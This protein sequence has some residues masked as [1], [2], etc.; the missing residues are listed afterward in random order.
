MSLADVK[1]LCVDAFSASKTRTPIFNGLT[2]F[3]SE[4]IAN[5][6]AG[7]LWI[8]GSFVTQKLDPKDCDLVLASDG[9]QLA[10]TGNTKIKD[11][12]TLRFAKANRAAVRAEFKCDAYY[13]PVY[14]ALHSQY[15]LTLQQ[16]QYWRKQFGHDRN[17]HPKGMAV[18][19]LPVPP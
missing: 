14:T 5:G 13:F 8:D 3:V 18:V 12:L 19:A 2:N 17:K 4:L 7:N 1:V 15:G 6:I 10:G 11:Y 9:N 16:D